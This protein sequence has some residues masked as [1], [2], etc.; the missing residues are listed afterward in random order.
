L[1]KEDI[2][3]IIDIVL[4]DFQK[5]LDHRDMSLRVTPGAKSLLADKGFDQTFGARFL[6]RT[7]QKLLEDPLAEE[8]LQGGFGEGSRIR[9][10]KKGD[11]LVFDEEREPSDAVDVEKEEAAS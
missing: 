8:L 5:R 4:D 2:T 10:T 11:A 6:K 9:V 1:S 3:T 7:I